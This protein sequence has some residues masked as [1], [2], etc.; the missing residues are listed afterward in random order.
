[1]SYGRVS[2]S[3]V[4]DRCIVAMSYGWNVTSSIWDNNSGYV[5]QRSH[6]Y[7]TGILLLCHIDEILSPTYEI[8]SDLM[9]YGRVSKS[10]V[11]DSNS[12]YVIR[13]RKR[14]R[15]FVL[16]SV[17]RERPAFIFIGNPYI[18]KSLESLQWRHN[19][20]D[21]VSNHQPHGCLL[22]RFFKAQTKKTSKLSVTGD[23]WTPRTK[24]H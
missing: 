6:L 2:K 5:I 15:D 16:I 23:R 24:G 7:E 10:Y 20:H 19:G 3:C 18:V 12:P 14:L 11:W 4:W 1:M 21:G 9:S 17:D 22:N 8:A 13:M